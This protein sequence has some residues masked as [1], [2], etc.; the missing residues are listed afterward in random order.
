MAPVV[1]ALNALFHRIEDLLTAE[2]RFTADAA[3]ELRTP[4]AAIRT[5]AQVAWAEADTDKRRHAL[6][7]TLAGCDRAARLIDQLLMLARLEAGPA[8]TRTEVDLTALARR[9]VTELAGQALDKAQDIELIAPASRRVEGHEVLLAALLRNFV[10]N[11]IRYSPSQAHIRV[12]VHEAGEVWLDVEDSGPG[13]SEADLGRLGERFFRG[14]GH[15]APGSG[16]GWSIASRIAAA[17]GCH[18]VAMRSA[19][20][21]GLRV[22]VVEGLTPP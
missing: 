7:A 20:L 5:Q 15:Q 14:E 10:D 6:Q 17:H 18:V 12:R 16:L 19:D 8:P 21:G 1:A 13:L 11:A 9:V 3:H 4:I 22:Q 2:R